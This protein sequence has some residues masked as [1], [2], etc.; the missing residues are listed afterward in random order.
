MVGR[1][2]VIRLGAEKEQ[3]FNEVIRVKANGVD[4]WPEG[5][6]RIVV[7]EN[8]RVECRPFTEEGELN[9]VLIGDPS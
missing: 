4:I 7:T 8:A 2:S 1:V 3:V 6:I 5:P 9:E